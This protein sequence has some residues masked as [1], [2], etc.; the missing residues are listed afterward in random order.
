MKK[1]LGNFGL[2]AAL[3]VLVSPMTWAANKGSNDASGSS[4]GNAWGT[5]RHC[6]I[7]P[8]G[9]FDKAAWFAFKSDPANRH[10]GPFNGTCP[11]DESNPPST[12]P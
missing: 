3:S 6:F 7:K 9:T 8:D 1:S 11:I 12:N 5:Y 4:D 10:M 2:V